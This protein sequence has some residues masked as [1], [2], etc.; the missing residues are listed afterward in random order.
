MLS[1]I[2]DDDDDFEENINIS[3]DEYLIPELSQ[4]CSI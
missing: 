3:I 4:Q 1:K 2:C